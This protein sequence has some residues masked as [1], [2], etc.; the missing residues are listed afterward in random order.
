MFWK[1]VAIAVAQTVLFAI[2]Y[3]IWR[4]ADRVDEVA[5][6]DR[7]PLWEY[8]IYQVLVDVSFLALAVLAVL[9]VYAT[10]RL[11][12][13]DPDWALNKELLIT[14]LKYS[15]ACAVARGLFEAVKSFVNH[16][17][18]LYDTLP[19]DTAAAILKCKHASDSDGESED[20]DAKD[21]CP[22]SAD[23]LEA[24]SPGIGAKGLA[25][26][27][28]ALARHAIR[29]SLVHWIMAVYLGLG[30]VFTWGMVEYLALLSTPAAALANKI[31]VDSKNVIA[32]E[33]RNNDSKKKNY[34]DIP[35]DF[36]LSVSSPGS[37]E[38][39]DT[40]NDDSNGN[41][42]VSQTGSPPASPQKSSNSGDGQ[43]G[44]GSGEGEN[45]SVQGDTGNDTEEGS[46]TSTVSVGNIPVSMSQ[47]PRSIASDQKGT[48]Y[49][50][51][52][53]GTPRSTQT[54]GRGEGESGSVQGDTGN[55]DSNGNAQVSQTGSQPASPQKSSNSGDEQG[56]DKGENGSENGK[57]RPT[58]SP[59][60]REGSD[61][62]GNGKGII[63]DNKGGPENKQQNQTTGADGTSTPRR[64]KKTL[65]PI[66]TGELSE[67]ARQVVEGTKNVSGRGKKGARGRRG[68][69]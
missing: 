15:G 63:G 32:E 2:V 10:R 51:S 18:Y 21:K 9:A 11:L 13:Q 55:D 62:D 22:L 26:L 60:S 52:V 46:V 25:R 27:P 20:G 64:Y 5:C 14:L 31:E 29:Q 53:Q 35:K 42:Q 68:R 39:D 65:S 19:P 61:N 44:Q 45:G 50:D 12:E 59:K 1:L 41:A 54:K 6:K 66:N 40:G 7:M 16:E 38:E 28:R 56:S 47:S 8:H 4:A 24:I 30:T 23:D 37:A 69:K 33:V 49:G 34:E 3:T 17:K 58:G 57:P 43:N 36:S 48:E 67:A